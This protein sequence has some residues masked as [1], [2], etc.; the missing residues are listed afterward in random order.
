[1]Q[2][3]SEKM[4]LRKTRLKSTTRR[5]RA[6]VSAPKKA[7]YS[8]NFE[9]RKVASYST[10]V[11]EYFKQTKRSNFFFWTSRHVPRLTPK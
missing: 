1:M 3:I 11:R 9:K 10:D 7:V 2:A 5:L 8:S 4:I 6:V